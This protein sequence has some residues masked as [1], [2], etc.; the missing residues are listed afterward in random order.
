MA[1]RPQSY[2]VHQAS[3]INGK[4]VCGIE[5]PLKVAALEDG[6]IGVGPDATLGCP[7]TTALEIWMRY[8]VQPAAFAY[9]GMPIVEIKQISAYSLPHPQQR[10]RRRALRARLRQR[11]R[12][13][14]LQARQRSRDH[15]QI[16]LDGAAP[17]S[18][19][20]C[21]EIYSSACKT[22]KT[23]LGPGARLSQRPFPRR[24]RPPRQGRD[25]HLLQSEAAGRRRRR[26]APFIGVEICR[27]PGP[28]PLRPGDR[29]YRLDQG[30][31]A[32]G[33]RPARA[34]LVAAPRRLDPSATAYDRPIRQGCRRRIARTCRIVPPFRGD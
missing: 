29:L 33:H 28:A 10:A 21:R 20:S 26:G 24:S 23:V 31:G 13:R 8:S 12:H 1:Q 17:T 22:F 34:T 14:R 6:T 25:L 4:G 3:A 18:D 15:G 16:R 2:F 30:A 7:M 5:Y 11:P 9:F 19:A 32:G 27:D